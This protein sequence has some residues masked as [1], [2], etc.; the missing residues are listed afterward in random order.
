MANGVPEQGQ[1]PGQF[2][3]QFLVLPWLPHHVR[4][5]TDRVHGRLQVRRFYRPFQ[6]PLGSA[7]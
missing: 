1:L 5:R 6:D 4:R 2:A 3:P 7:V